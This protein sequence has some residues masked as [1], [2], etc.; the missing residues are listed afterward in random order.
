MDLTRIPTYHAGI[1]QSKAYRIL[2]Q[3]MASLLKKHGLTMMDWAMLG[4]VYEAGK[5]GVRITSLAEQLDT[6]KAFVTTHINLLEAKELVTR[7]VDASDTR[8]KIVKIHS[9]AKSTVQKIEAELRA[10]MSKNLYSVISPADLS[11]YVKVL[12]QIASINV[13]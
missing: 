7:G 11:A 10:D 8:A 5:K 6:T 9:G 1:A 2:R 3:L 12:N 13:N 4:L